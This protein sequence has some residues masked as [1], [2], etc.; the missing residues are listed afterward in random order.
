MAFSVG[1]TVAGSAPVSARQQGSSERPLESSHPGQEPLLRPETRGS[2]VVVH[3]EE[4]AGTGAA[5]AGAKTHNI[6]A[7]VHPREGGSRV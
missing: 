6:H 3:A 4:G 5:W 7:F 1:L 2:V